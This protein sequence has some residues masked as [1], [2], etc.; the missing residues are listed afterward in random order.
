MASAGK[1]EIVNKKNKKAT[2]T[3]NEKKSARKAL[4]ENMPRIDPVPPLK[5]S[6]TL[7]ELGFEKI[8]KKQNKEQVPPT[9]AP[10]NQQPRSFSGGKMVK[11]SSGDSGLK[12]KRFPS[13]DTAVKALDL[14]E[15]Q[16]Q[17]DKSQN[18][19][20]GNPSVWVKD[21][22]GYL[23][24]K[25]QAPES[26]PTLSQYSFDY[27]YSLANKELRNIIKSLLGK[28][29]DHL[30]H[31]FDHCI[32]T[33]LRE[34]DKAAG[35]SL[36]GYRVCIQAILLD[37]PHI[38]TMNLGKYL[39]LLRSQYNKPNKCLSIMWA[40]GQAGTDLTE[41]LKV[42]LNIMLP[43]LGVKA[44]S[45]YAISYLDRLLM[46]HSNLSKGFG[47]IGPKDFFPLLDFAYMPNNSLSPNLQD[48]LRHLYPRLKVLAFGAKPDSTLHTYFPSFLSR[49]TP[50]CP[51]EMKKELLKCMVECL[52][53]DSNSFSVWRQLYTKHLSQSSLL[54]N[55]LLEIWNNLPAKVQKALQETIRSFKVTNEELSGKSTANSQEIQACNTA[56]NNLLQKLKGGGFP[57]L[58]LL[59]VLTIFAAGFVMHDIRTHGSFNASSSAH[60]LQQSG[61]MSV[62][63]QAWNKISH[64]SKQ[65]YS[66]IETNTPYYYSEAVTMFG[67]SL[68]LVWRRLLELIIYT[69][70]TLST[71][72]AW[73]VEN[74]PRFTEWLRSSLPDVMLQFVEYVKELLLFVL[75]NYILPALEYIKMVIKEWWKQLV[76]SCEGE[77]SRECLKT[78]FVNMIHLTWSY[79]QN[80]MTTIK[81]WTSS[82]ISNH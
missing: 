53:T 13:L 18:L 3:R 63:Q 31:F 26:D 4:S 34:Q 5:P 30:E 47:T 35:E 79:L 8:G 77:I 33:M 62:S 58:R 70:E 29:S 49:A 9:S 66:W 10:E 15:L 1:W 64:Y 32:Y 19:F 28:T 52:T 17:L 2:L 16:E 11:K 67:P 38:G 59:L 72:M 60:V 6:E 42:W 51:P 27:P 69:K 39:E 81:N 44:L 36:H 57:W 25:L 7:F 71:H 55:N 23:N 82:M 54:L 41:G 76:N 20:P 46:M 50:N 68:E 56:C 48:Q 12:H 65:G 75:Q 22:A 37:K 61:M 73:I 40:L 24:Y 45:A 80:T 14:K 43:V 78:H 21:L 74:L